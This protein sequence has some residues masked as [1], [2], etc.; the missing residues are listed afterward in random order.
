MEV[1]RVARVFVIA[2]LK[3]LS[4]VH[5][6]CSIAPKISPNVNII[7]RAQIHVNPM[8]KLTEDVSSRD[9]LAKSGSCE[10]LV[11]L[12]SRRYNVGFLDCL[13][14]DLHS[15]RVTKRERMV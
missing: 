6:F 2:S 1:S 3:L 11:V 12:L 15:P 14:A 7:S 5:K 10:L 4:F 8:S 13:F 9:S